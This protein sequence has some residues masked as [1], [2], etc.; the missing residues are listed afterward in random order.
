[1]LMDRAK[2]LIIICICASSVWGEYV[3]ADGAANKETDLQSAVTQHVHLRGNGLQ[4]TVNELTQ[5]G[6]DP[7]R[8]TAI[9]PGGITISIFSTNAT[10]I[11]WER[12]SI[13]SASTNEPNGNAATA[14][15]R[16]LGTIEVD[17]F[18]VGTYAYIFT[19]LFKTDSSKGSAEWVLLGESSFALPAMQARK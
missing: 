8:L 19:W 4:S 12:L 16:S 1:M 11:G 7:A 6:I 17:H 15:S 10:N 9:S 18:Q 2:F 14:G 13:F 3:H 5:I